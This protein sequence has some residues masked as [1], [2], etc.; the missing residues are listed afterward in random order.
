M[1]DG[2]AREGKFLLRFRAPV[3]R[4]NETAG[5]PTRVAVLWRYAAAGKG[6]LP[7]ADVGE[8][9]GAFEDAVCLALEPDGL[10]V[11]AAVLTFDGARQWELYARDGGE[12]TERIRAVA[13][14]QG[15]GS[16]DV[17]L[18]DD[19]EWAHVRGDLIGKLAPANLEDARS[20]E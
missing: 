15:A 11:L 20:P 14:A 12:C 16:I 9:M 18:S 5:Y 19:P 8:T 6:T 10:A 4:A 3:L 13:T 2:V 17:V 1:A 7:M